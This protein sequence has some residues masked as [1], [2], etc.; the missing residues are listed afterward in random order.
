M[1]GAVTSKTHNLTSDAHSARRQS[2]KKNW[3]STNNLA[4]ETALLAAFDKAPTNK[5]CRRAPLA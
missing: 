2:V 1:I 4:M 3:L 5:I